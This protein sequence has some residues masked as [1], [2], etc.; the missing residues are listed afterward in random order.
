MMPTE[1]WI[2]FPKSSGDGRVG[3]AR[4]TIRTLCRER[5]WALQERPVPPTAPV[6]AAEHVKQVY[7]RVH[8]ARVA[9]LSVQEIGAA[10]PV[11]LTRPQSRPG[12]MARDDLRS[13]R[14]LCRHKA[15]FLRLRCDR[16]H[17]GWAS[18]FSAWLGRTE[19][20]GSADPRSLPLHVFAAEG[21]W[22]RRLASAAGRAAFDDRF[23]SSARRV[24]RRDFAWEHG[25]SHGREPL[26]VAGFLLPAGFHWDVKTTR[27]LE[28]W[29][30]TE[31]WR[32]RTYL[33]VYPDASVRGREPHAKQIR[34]P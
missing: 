23:G 22:S 7:Q 12:A 9:I 28:L 19:C 6:I 21:T 20:C 26:Q 24:D 2:F 4:N 8:R 31:G 34:L 10:G 17:S 18:A 27:D 16:D 11:F 1:V 14:Q 33:N 32:V 5:G 13:L 15:F 25:P 29:T 30:P 3:A